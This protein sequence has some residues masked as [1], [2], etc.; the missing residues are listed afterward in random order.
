MKHIDKL[1][2]RAFYFLQSTHPRTLEADARYRFVHFHML[3]TSPA[4]LYKHYDPSTSFPWI[5]PLMI[6]DLSEIDL[7]LPEF[8]QADL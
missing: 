2:S 5:S 1:L 3:D 8:G 7:N 6:L 4:L